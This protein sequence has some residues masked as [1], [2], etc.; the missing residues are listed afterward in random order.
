MIEKIYDAVEA[1][2]LYAIEEL[3]PL[4]EY[5]IIVKTTDDWAFPLPAEVLKT[6]EIMISISGWTREN[7]YLEEDNLHV[8]TAFGEEEN[9]RVFGVDEILGIVADG[10]IVLAKGFERSSE[11]KSKYIEENNYTV[12]GMIHDSETKEAKESMR[13]M[14]K[15]NK[16]LLKKKQN[17][18]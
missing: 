12:K 2:M 16:D 10:R 4:S 9:S 6:K 18:K 1:A 11:K 5:G 7:T 3:E 13:L 8:I 14:E 15:H 17:K